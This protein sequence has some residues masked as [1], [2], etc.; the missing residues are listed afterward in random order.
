MGGVGVNVAQNLVLELGH[1][2][3]GERVTTFNA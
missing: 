2:E 3:D 1:R